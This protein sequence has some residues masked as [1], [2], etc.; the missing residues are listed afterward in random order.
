MNYA[1]DWTQI[2]AQ[3]EQEW[4][5]EKRRE[6][7]DAEKRRIVALAERSWFRRVFPWRIVIVRL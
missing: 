3:A 4:R 1:V 2:K 7:I 6:L 5:E